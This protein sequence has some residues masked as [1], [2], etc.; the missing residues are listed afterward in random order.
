M[1]KRRCPSTSSIRGHLFHEVK[2]TSKVTSAEGS[3]YSPATRVTDC[4]AFRICTPVR[5]LRIMH[6]HNYTRQDRERKREREE[7]RTKE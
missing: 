6:V 3:T 2:N 7:E 5:M 1:D 4:R